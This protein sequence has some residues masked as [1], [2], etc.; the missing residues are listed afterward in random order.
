MKTAQQGH[1]VFLPPRRDIAPGSGNMRE[2]GRITIADVKRAVVTVC[3]VPS[4]YLTS[5]AREN[6]AWMLARQIA[7]ALSIELTGRSLPFVG[8]QFGGRDHTTVRYARIRVGERAVADPRV[9][10]IV[11][12]VRASAMGQASV[13]CPRTVTSLA[14]VVAASKPPEPAPG[15]VW[16]GGRAAFYPEFGQLCT[17]SGSINLSPVQCALVEVLLHASGS[18]ADR[19]SLF[20]ALGRHGIRVER[21]AYHINGLRSLF[22]A[23]RMPLTLHTIAGQGYALTWRGDVPDG[24]IAQRQRKASDVRPP[25]ATEAEIHRLRKRG[26]SFGAIAKHLRIDPTYVADELGIEVGAQ[27][28]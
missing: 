24:A 3:S 11:D 18:A 6:Q 20:A 26:W 5:H 10:G 22:G 25:S 1:D 17:S 8:S 15:R 9:K 13:A 19:Q 12:A 16:L 7:M 2:A 23:T 14:D 21:L 4:W 27:R 28:W